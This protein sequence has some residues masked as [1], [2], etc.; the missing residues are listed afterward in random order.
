MAKKTL[1]LEIAGGLTFCFLVLFW[2]VTKIGS[3]NISHDVSQ[4]ILD[5]QRRMGLEQ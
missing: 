3:D 5:L 1:Y 4:Q 2:A